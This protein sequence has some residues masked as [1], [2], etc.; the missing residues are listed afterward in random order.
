MTD[1]LNRSDISAVMERVEIS[2]AHIVLDELPEIA[3]I[4][5]IKIKLLELPEV[6]DVV[7]TEP[8][9]CSSETGATM[10]QS[11]TGNTADNNILLRSEPDAI[12]EFE[13]EHKKGGS[14]GELK[15]RDGR[16]EKEYHKMTA[17]GGS[18]RDA[19]EYRVKESTLIGIKELTDEQRE[20]IKKFTGWSDEIINAIDSMAEYKIYRSAG[21]VE[22]EIGDK[23][24]LINPNIDMNQ[25]DEKG[26]TNF[27]RMEQGLAPLGKDGMSMQLHHIGQHKDSPLAQLSDTEHKQN[28]KILHPSTLPTEVH[29]K[30]NKWNTERAQ[31]WKNFVSQSRGGLNN[32]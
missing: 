31:H 17:S 14:Y 7:I 5:D 4:D 26:R 25:L 11:L 19:Q 2:Q 22:A 1:M 6:A 28:Y 15:S 16:E 29:G 9:I 13:I 32:A 18:S 3:D 21:L 8:V 12:K 10:R 24:C 27:E 20:I 23:K 30:D